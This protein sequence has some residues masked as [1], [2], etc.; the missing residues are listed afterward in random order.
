MRAARR[1]VCGGCTLCCKLFAV[2]A[3]D[4]LAGVWCAHA[5]KGQGCGIYETRPASCREFACAWL[6]GAFRETERPDRIHGVAV[7]TTSGDGLVVHEDPGYEGVARAA[8]RDT[9]AAVVDM[10]RIVFAVCGERRLLVTRE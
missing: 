9:I 7:P 1:R 2:G 6:Q 4:K 10:G 3:L 5:T 8:L